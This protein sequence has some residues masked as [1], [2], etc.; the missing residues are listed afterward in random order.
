M[1]TT[2]E[3]C[4]SA[5]GLILMAILWVFISTFPEGECKRVFTRTI[6]STDGSS[7]TEQVRVAVVPAYSVPVR[8]GE[9]VTVGDAPATRRKH[10]VKNEK[11]RRRK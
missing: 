6:V 3:Y 8:L 1:N 5:S 11:E 4:P 7:V 2:H 10:K 9:I